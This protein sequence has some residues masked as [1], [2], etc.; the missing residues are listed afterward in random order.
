MQITPKLISPTPASPLSSNC[1][2]ATPFE[3]LMFKLE[4]L[5]FLHIKAPPPVSSCSKWYLR[6]L[7]GQKPE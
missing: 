1:P 6:S 7:T 5:N 2:L 3:Y 4:L